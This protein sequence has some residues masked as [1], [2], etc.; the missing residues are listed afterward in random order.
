MG[1]VAANVLEESSVGMILTQGDPTSNL[2]N[3]LAGVDFRYVNSSFAGGRSLQGDAWLQKSDTENLVGDDAA[4]GLGLRIPGNTGLRGELGLTRIERN[5]NPALGF[6][7]RR[8]I[9]E[10]ELKL[11]N[12]WRPRGSALRTI[13]S[14][15]DADRIDYLDDGSVQ[16]QTISLQAL[17]VELNS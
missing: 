5:F 2:D 6:V 17:N 3:S 7:R 13:F 12:T 14:G 8:G 11:G 16:S 4:F 9:E 15:V 1:R 10:L